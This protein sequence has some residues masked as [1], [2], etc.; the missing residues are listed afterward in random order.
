VP[1]LI[2]YA[3]LNPDKLLFASTGNGS[4]MHLSL[5]LFKRMTGTQMTHVPFK[6]AQQGVTDLI[7]GQVHVMCDNMSSIGPQARAGRVRALA[8]TSAKRSAAYPELPTVAESGLSG[9]DVVTFGGLIAP[10]GVPRPI[11]DL[12]NKELNKAVDSSTLREKFALNGSEPVGG[13]HRT[14]CGIR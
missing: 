4:S 11:V 7:A 5:E 10:A 13:T 6:G 8:V 2:E 9:F 3:K 12:L 14:V 1:E